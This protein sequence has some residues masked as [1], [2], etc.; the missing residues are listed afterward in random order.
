MTEKL[1]DT[2]YNHS[3]SLAQK[4]ALRAF[5]FYLEGGFWQHE[6]RIRE[7]EAR[8][9]LDDLVR[10]IEKGIS[11]SHPLLLE[12]KR[13]FREF[14][15]PN[16][17]IPEG[18]EN[19]PKTGPLVL[20]INHSDEGARLRGNDLSSVVAYETARAINDFSRR[21]R[22]AIEDRKHYFDRLK[23]LQDFT[24]EFTK[25]IMANVAQ[26]TGMILVGSG[27]NG[28]AGSLLRGDILGIY[29][30]GKD[31]KELSSIDPKAAHYIKRLSYLAPIIPV[32][33]WFKRNWGVY[34]V[35]FGP[36]VFYH[37]DQADQEVADDLGL[38]MAMLLPENMRGK[39]RN[40]Q[41]D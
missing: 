2:R 16:N 21:F 37:K 38:R 33:A 17:V 13:T 36:E 39:Y 31:G 40:R 18:L 19:L 29:P 1:G 20:V 5:R 23:F 26:V 12:R 11:G 22:F 14:S 15:G 32:G 4:L 41:P 9:G 34:R 6:Y 27:Q 10:D 25:P 35:N 24:H 8:R 3:L 28:I 30:E 7:R